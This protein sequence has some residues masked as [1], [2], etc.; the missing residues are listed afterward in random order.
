MISA[1][2]QFQRIYEMGTSVFVADETIRFWSARYLE[3]YEE[4]LFSMEE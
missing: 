2:G 3:D 1:T 4:Y